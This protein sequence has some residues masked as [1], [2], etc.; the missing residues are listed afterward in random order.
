MLMTVVIFTPLLYGLKAFAVQAVLPDVVRAL[1]VDSVH[2]R[3]STLFFEH[4]FP[5]CWW[6]QLPHRLFFRFG[7]TNGE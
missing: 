3:K 6:L 4:L 5:R 1:R 7:N 2:S